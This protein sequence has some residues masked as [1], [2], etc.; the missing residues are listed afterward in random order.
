MKTIVPNMRSC[1]WFLKNDPSEPH[2]RYKTVNTPSTGRWLFYALFSTLFIIV[3]DL[4]IGLG[5]CHPDDS[6]PS[7]TKHVLFLGSYDY[8]IPVYQEFLPAFLSMMENS[9]VNREDLF[10]EFLDLQHVWEKDSKRAL[11][12]MIR[13]K[14]SRLHI[15]LIVT[16]HQGALD[17][18]LEEGKDILPEV[19]VLAWMPIGSGT[20]PSRFDE[21]KTGRRVLQAY[22]RLDI[23]GTLERALDLFRETRHVVF[24]SGVWDTESQITQEIKAIFSSFG[25]N[26]EF[27][28]TY[29]LTMEEVLKRVAHLPADSIIIYYVVL[30]DKTGRSFIVPDVARNIA[31]VANAPVFCVYKSSLVDGVIGGSVLSHGAEGARIADIAL[32]MLAGEIDRAQQLASTAAKPVL[33]FDWQQIKKWQGDVRNLPEETV[34]INSTVS[35]WE[36]YKW[37]F[38]AFIVF[39]LIQSGLIVSLTIQKTRKGRAEAAL[40]R[41]EEQIRKLNV[42]LEQRVRDRTTQLEAANTKLLE[43]DQ[44]KSMFIASMSHEL[45]TP[46]NSIIGFSS[47]MINEWVGPLNQEQKDNLE[48]VLRSGKHLLALINDVIDVSK[49]E[50]GKI[51]PVVEDFDVHDAVMEA[52]ETFKKDIET[53]GLEMILQSTHLIM[54]TDRRRFLQCLLNLLSNATKFTNRGSIGVYVKSAADKLL[55][56]ISVEDTGIGIG[57]EDLRELF[58]PFVRL[59]TAGGSAIPGTGLGLYLTRKLVKEIL[60]GE[61]Q[62]TSTYGKGS[63]FTIHLPMRI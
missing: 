22:A 9:G 63:R 51:D 12:D 17:L 52:V 11:L 56:T 35:L 5:T 49:I 43:L 1:L 7:G 14:Y 45:R 60:K 44:L 59:H 21:K 10:F 19:P 25:G 31:K 42:N 18:L 33:I 2:L 8:K 62:V 50:T 55:M 13:K 16:V 61:I 54:H 32:L 41:S 6:P 27:E 57:E 48:S 28:Y 4:W 40:R 30:M 15:D 47:I 23:K 46:L 53:K 38:T 58:S 29:D 37:Y 36:R 3:F 26:L 20:A 39:S 24:V 34:F